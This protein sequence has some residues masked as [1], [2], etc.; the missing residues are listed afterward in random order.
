MTNQHPLTPKPPIAI[1]GVSALM[2]GS[3]DSQGFWHDILSGRDLITE[4][5]RTH[6][7][8]RDY[9]DANPKVRDKTYA[10]RGAFLSEVEFDPMEFGVPPTALPAIDTAQLLALIVAQRVLQDA[11]QGQFS[12][13]NRERISVILGMAGA[14]ELFSHM[15]ARLGKPVWANALRES[16][17]QPQQADEICERIAA[18]YV[19]WQENTFPGLL[20]NVVAGRVANRLDLGGT[21]CVVDAAC[22]GSLAAVSIGLNELYSGQ[23]DVSI[24]GGVDT[25]NDIIMYMCFS[26]VGALSKTGD[27]RPFSVDADGTMIGEGLAMFALKRLADAERDGDRVYAVL[28]SIGTSSDGRAKSIYAPLPQGQAKALRRAYEAAGYEPTTV[29][30]VEAHGTGTIAGD[31]AEFEGLQSVF[32]TADSAKQYCALGS[33]KA[34]IGHTK[35][36]AGSAGLFKAVMALHHKILPP[37]AKVTQPNPKLKLK[38]S[39]FYLNTEARPWIRDNH[40]P[41][42][43][44]VS[45]FGFGGTNFHVALEE[46]T[47][48]AAKAWKVRTLP[49]ELVI[50][51]ADQPKDLLAWCQHTASQLAPGSLS[52]FAQQTQLHYDS[53]KP[54]RIALVAKDE[55]ELQQKLLQLADHLQTKPTQGLAA[56][57]IYYAWQQQPGKTAWLFPG[58]GSQYLTMGADLAMNFSVARQVWDHIANLGLTPDTPLHEVVFPRPVFNPED[59]AQQEQQL[60]LT[61]WAQPAI[62]AVSLSLMAVLKALGLKADCVAGHSFGEVTALHAAQVF[63][64]DSFVKIA[65]KRGELMADACKIS[66]A[67]TAVMTSLDKIQPLFANWGV[68]AVLANHNSPEQLVYSGKTEEIEKLEHHLKNAAIKFRRLSVAT[69]FH[70]PLVSGCCEPFKQFL[71]SLTVQRPEIPVYSNAEV[72]P[73]P[74]NAAAIRKRLGEQLAHS[75]RFVEQIEALYQ[76]GVRTFI[77]VGPSTVL[78]NLTQRCLQGR[79]HLAIALDQKGKNGVTSLWEGLAQLVIQGAALDFSAVW[80]EYAPIKNPADQVKAKFSVKLS[81]ANY[82]KPYPPLE[83]ETVTQGPLKTLDLTAKPASQPGLAPVSPA[84]MPPKPVAAAARVPTQPSAPPAPVAPITPAPAPMVATPAIPLQPAQPTQPQQGVRPPMNTLSPMAPRPM[85]TVTLSP[86]AMA[87]QMAPAW[88]QAYQMIQQQTADAHRYYQQTMAETHLAFLR[89]AETSFTGLVQLASGSPVVMSAPVMQPVSAPMPVLA[90]APALAPVQAYAPAPVMAPVAAP[91]PVMAPV[92][93]PVMAPAPAPVAATIPMPMAAPAP[94]MA[95][96]PAPVATPVVA[97]APAAAKPA[98]GID[99]KAALLNVVADKTGYPQDML[100]LSMALESDL[101]IDSIKRVEIFSALQ[102]QIPGLPEADTQQLAQLQTLGSILAFY[103]ADTAASA[104]VTSAPPVAAPV[105]PTPTTAP[106]AATEDPN[107]NTLKAALLDVVADKTGYPEEM[108]DLSMALESDLGIDSIKRVEIFSALQ[109][110]MPGLP[111]VET[112]QLAALATLGDI[113]SHYVES[114]LPAG[115]KKKQALN[116]SFSA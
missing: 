26:E 116:A 1:V 39:A 68:D 89:S 4:V 80:S 81:G 2:P 9:Y 98:P 12:Y 90:P 84:P 111:E 88:L 96:A 115:I 61:E 3:Q 8:T 15:S 29:E 49:T 16:G 87:P 92:P 27:C 20:G 44:G 48:P 114:A 78:T 59:K 99:L 107:S 71:K 110:K 31:L 60:T 106:A 69:A 42:R 67:M 36:T 46:Y 28:R 18:H 91:A 95:A 24:V 40:H 70:S 6:W 23:S 72:E 113:I 7:L 10:K 105:A 65:R 11:A 30:L 82:K 43:A 50:Y 74:A 37:T 22:A 93:A 25:L 73:Y 108:L 109:E 86:P 77:E 34:Q 75:V 101:G 35:A 63:D 62:G 32:G 103:G 51:S 104:A 5:P 33:V 55:T 41:R 47:G 53:A 64:T 14:T 66:G 21:N 13:Q 38:E 102:E 54:A 94:A 52:Y 57:G 112:S 58:Q 85:Q 79:A 83:G 97:P 100:D 56:K 19:T 17:F 76:E 45:A